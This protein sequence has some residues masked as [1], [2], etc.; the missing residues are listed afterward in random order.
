MKAQRY[1]DDPTR[2]WHWAVLITVSL[3]PLGAAA[4]CAMLAFP[5]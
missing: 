5:S 1:L 4:A 2:W 3:A